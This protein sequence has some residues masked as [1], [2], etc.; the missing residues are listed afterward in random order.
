MICQNCNKELPK[1]WLFCPTC[2][3]KSGGLSTPAV[4]A[5]KP[6]PS[7]THVSQTSGNTP[8][9]SSSPNYAGFWVRTLALLVDSIILWA[10]SAT[11]WLFFTFA[12]GEVGTLI[13]IAISAVI[14]LFYEAY[15]TSRDWYATPG[16]RAL[17]IWVADTNLQPLGFGLAMGRS[18]LKIA[19][20]FTFGLGYLMVAFTDKKQGLHDFM[21]RTVVLRR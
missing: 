3:A 17:K 8:S 14:S 1:G 16:K 12:A 18:L 4:P 20:L 19:N 5:P 11:L 10:V 6:P 13:G 2:R 15:F 7:S 9:Q 21:A